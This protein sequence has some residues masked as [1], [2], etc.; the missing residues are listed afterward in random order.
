MRDDKAFLFV[1]LWVPDGW[2][3]HECYSA[4][5]KVSRKPRESITETHQK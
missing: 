4:H 3:A 1:L 2:E 5:V